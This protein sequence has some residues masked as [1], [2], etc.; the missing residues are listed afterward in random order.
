MTENSGERGERVGKEGT[1]TGHAYELHLHV[2]YCLA[3]ILPPPPFC[4]LLEMMWGGGRNSEDL[5]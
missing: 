5:C 4:N 3:V 1:K 2:P